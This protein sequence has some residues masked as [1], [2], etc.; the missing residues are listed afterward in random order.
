MT[1]EDGYEEIKLALHHNVEQA[2]SS[3]TNTYVNW[4]GS[5]DQVPYPTYT[6]K[7]LFLN[8]PCNKIKSD[9]VPLKQI[10]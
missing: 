2:I 8:V 6:F 7:N 9:P 4:M 3:H 5:W 1:E 10:S